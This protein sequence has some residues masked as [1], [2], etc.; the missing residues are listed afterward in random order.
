MSPGRASQRSSGIAKKGCADDAYRGVGTG[1]A[2]PRAERC[3]ESVRNSHDGPAMDPS[4]AASATAASWEINWDHSTK[5]ERIG[6][7]FSAKHPQ[8]IP[9]HDW[10]VPGPQVAT[11]RPAG[12]S[13]WVEVRRPLLDRL[14]RGRAVPRAVRRRAGS[15]AAR[16]AAL[17]RLAG[18][19][20]R[21]LLLVV[22]GVV[23]QREAHPLHRLPDLLAVLARD[24]VP[25]RDGEAH[26]RHE[27]GVV[28]VRGDRHP[29]HPARGVA[30]VSCYKH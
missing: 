15:V 23:H 16:R 4:A 21:R 7:E 1:P 12:V 11:I 8:S 6:E 30:P 10:G 26:A 29:R 22:E 27:T 13:M 24:D 14:R 2:E 28:P 19:V 25:L 18:E 17:A 5:I 9:Q 3:W 20:D